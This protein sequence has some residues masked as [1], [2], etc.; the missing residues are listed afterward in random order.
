[1]RFIFK[2][3]VL[4]GLIILGKWG[5]DNSLTEDK[6][7]AT[8]IYPMYSQSIDLNILPKESNQ[9]IKKIQVNYNY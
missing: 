5:K 3:F 9:T 1:M 2:V 7:R 8:I 6:P 4:V